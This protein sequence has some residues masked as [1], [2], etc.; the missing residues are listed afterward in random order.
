MLLDIV[1]L[2]LE[3]PIVPE[4][5]RGYLTMVSSVLIIVFRYTSSAEIKKI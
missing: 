2:F 3:N 5:Y 1:N 4:K